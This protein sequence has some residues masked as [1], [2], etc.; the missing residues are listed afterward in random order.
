MRR[1]DVRAS[2]G[3]G[4]PGYRRCPLGERNV[5]HHKPIC[6]PQVLPLVMVL[7]AWPVHVKAVT[8]PPLGL[9]PPMTSVPNLVP[10][11]QGHLVREGPPPPSRAGG[12]DRGQK[13]QT[14]ALERLEPPGGA[15]FHAEH[16]PG[17]PKRGTSPRLERSSSLNDLVRVSMSSTQLDQ[18]PRYDVK[19][20][21]Q[22]KGRKG[23]SKS[24]MFSRVSSKKLARREQLKQQ[25]VYV[26]HTQDK[27][28]KGTV[29][30]AP[31]HLKPIFL[32]LL[33]SDMYLARAL[34][35]VIP[36]NEIDASSQAIVH[37]FET[38]GK[39]MDLV[40]FLIQSEF[41]SSRYHNTLF[42][43]NTISSKAIS[44]YNALVGRDYLRRTLRPLVYALV[45]TEVDLEVDKNRLGSSDN[46]EENVSNL[47]A[48]VQ[49]FLVRIIRSVDSYPLACRFICH[50]IMSR[51]RKYYP[52]EENLPYALAGAF[53]FLRFICPAIVFPEKYGVWDGE[54][55]TPVRRSLKVMSKV[56][57]RLTLTGNVNSIQRDQELL[58]MAAFIIDQ[59]DKRTI[60]SF[61]ELVATPPIDEDV[62]ENYTVVH[63]NINHVNKVW[64]LIRQYED[65]ILSK[66]GELSVS[67]DVDTS[68]PKEDFTRAVFVALKISAP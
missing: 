15:G 8:G 62:K 12:R 36:K 47:H 40:T 37:V 61:F 23:K 4:L 55:T 42:R 9:P 39:A 50:Q 48:A 51:A 26:R 49:M 60:P 29:E 31:E 44:Y 45:Y 52:E 10:M 1:G 5:T 21:G 68:S 58:P 19:L 20:P 35:A 66:L 25:L 56:L 59:K 38:G 17:S 2:R 24:K 46:I 16:R 57:Q 14:V 34:C 41:D 63:P 28:S 6:L 11:P 27:R 33:R 22:G 65:E 64:D 13:A 67:E 30:A 32:L 54:I 18:D 7:P 43:D 53:F 3:T